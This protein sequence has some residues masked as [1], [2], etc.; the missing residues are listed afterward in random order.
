MEKVLAQN[1]DNPHINVETLKLAIEECIRPDTLKCT[2]TVIN[3]I[4]LF[5]APKIKYDLSKRKFVLETIRP[6]IYTEA[7]YK[8]EIFKNRYELL[9]YRTLK[10]DL[11]SPPKLGQKK[12]DWIELVPIEHLLSENK[13]GNIC[14]MGLLTQLTEGQYYLEDPGGTIKI[15]LQRAISFKNLKKIN[16]KFIFK[17][18]IFF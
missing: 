15:D 18:M 1:L 8:T 13:T 7:Q 5:N 4:D 14:V 17:H 16:M 6:D 10:H 12:E 9:W 2:E 3:V 11:F